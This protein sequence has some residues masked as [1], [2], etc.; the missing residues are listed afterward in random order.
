MPKLKTARGAAR[1]FR[2]TA[3]GYKHKRTGKNHLLTKKGQKRKR[4]L[5]G[6]KNVSAADASKLDRML[7]YDAR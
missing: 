5:R 7:P 4:Q 2:R 3:N 6:F 1:R